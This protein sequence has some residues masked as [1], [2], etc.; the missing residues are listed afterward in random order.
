MLTS[1]RLLTGLVYC[2]RCGA[3]MRYQKWGDKG[4]KLSCY[5][6]Q[7]SKAYLIHDP[8]CENPKPWADEVE[9]AVVGDFLGRSFEE[10]GTAAEE[11]GIS[12]LEMMETQLQQAQKKLGRLYLLFSDQDDDVLLESIET[13]RRT[14]SDLQA[15]IERERLM[16]ADEMRRSQKQ[17]EIRRLAQAWPHMT[18][19]EQRTVIREAIERVEIDGSRIDISYRI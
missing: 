16:Q 6:Q 14:I 8:D 1:D 12:P 5:S 2:G 13:Q 3:R 7:T 17:E 4:Y 18:I 9:E 11:K 10:T 19:D 15:R